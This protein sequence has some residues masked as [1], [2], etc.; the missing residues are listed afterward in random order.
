M[1]KIVEEVILRYREKLY[2]YKY[3][4]NNSIQ[5]LYIEIYMYSFNTLN[6]K[7]IFTNQ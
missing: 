4:T 3:T 1:N 2:K 6:N 7:V 5:K